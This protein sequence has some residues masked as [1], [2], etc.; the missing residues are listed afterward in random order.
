MTNILKTMCLLFRRELRGQAE[1]LR[2]KID[3]KRKSMWNDLAFGSNVFLL[4][5][6]VSKCRGRPE[7][8]NVTLLRSSTSLGQG[9]RA[10]TVEEREGAGMRAS[11]RARTS[12]RAR[13]GDVAACGISG[14]TL[15][16]VFRLP[17]EGKCGCFEYREPPRVVSNLSRCRL[18]NY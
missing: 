5:P 2:K 8:R 3:E 7:A 11:T 15:L 13:T 9:P 16:C 14:R 4:E 12:S 18:F 1:G 17:V 10:H 6:K